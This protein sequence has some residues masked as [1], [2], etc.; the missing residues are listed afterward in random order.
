MI[1]P[2]AAPRRELELRRRR[3]CSWRTAAP[4]G[5]VIYRL[6][7][8]L[9]ASLRQLSLDLCLLCSDAGG[10]AWLARLTQLRTLQL[11]VLLCTGGCEENQILLTVKL[12]SHGICLLRACR[13]TNRAACRPY[14]NL[15]LVLMYALLRRVQA[16]R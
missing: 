8:A 7:S 9:A 10:V 14:A 6:V 5:P 11:N 15:W 2:C 3:G 13:Q 16:S 12:A 4:P 1:P